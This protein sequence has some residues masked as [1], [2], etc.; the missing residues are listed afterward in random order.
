MR[1]ADISAVELP[2]LP[3][4]E[5]WGDVNILSKAIIVVLAFLKAGFT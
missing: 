1:E 4:T 2:G 5:P 3:A